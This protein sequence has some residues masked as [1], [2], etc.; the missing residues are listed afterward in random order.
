M[1]LN[2]LLCLRLDDFEY[3]YECRKQAFQVCEIRSFT[4]DQVIYYRTQYRVTQQARQGS[5][6]KQKNRAQVRWVVGIGMESEVS[7]NLR[8]T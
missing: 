8:R 7:R 4:D 3:D 6:A 1:I 5:V 2:A